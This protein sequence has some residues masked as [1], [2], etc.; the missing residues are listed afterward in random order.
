MKTMVTGG[1]GFIGS[2]LVDRL[3]GDGHYVVVVDDCSTGREE[4]L[5]TVRDHAN[6]KFV[7]GS[8]LDGG[9]VQAELEGCELVFHLA[10]AVGVSHVLRDPIWAIVTNTQGTHTV[11]EC[12][13][14]LGVRVVFASTSE[15]YGESN[16]APFREDG[17]RIL[18]PTWIHR[19]CYSTSKAVD[20][21]LCFAYRDRGLEMSIVRYFN[22]YGPRMDPAGY[23]S[24]IARFITQALGRRPLTVHGDGDQSRCFTYVAEAVEAT[25][26]AGT[27]RSALG[28]V[29]NVGSRFECT[30][31]E[32]AQ[33]VIAATG[34]DSAIRHVPYE[35]VYGFDFADTRRRVPDVSKAKDVLGWEAALNLEQGLARTLEHRLGSPSG[36]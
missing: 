35:E 5:A 3:L 22:I 2:H 20:E 32:L 16:H 6:L 23:G 31:N 27:A 29:F 11:L 8:V 14:Q 12:A 21:H 30:I 4:N 15:V 1:A 24:V 33:R 19:W 17:L 36:G 9:L 34:S 28:D 13:A 26:R 7:R 18:G 25:I 10:A